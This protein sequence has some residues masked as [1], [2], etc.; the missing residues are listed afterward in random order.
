MCD[1]TYHK[2]YYFVQHIDKDHIIRCNLCKC[3]LDTKKDN[4]H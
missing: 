2:E 4:I 3:A 1:K